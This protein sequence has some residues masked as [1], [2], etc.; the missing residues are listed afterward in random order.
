MR[1]PQIQP[2]GIMIKPSSNPAAKRSQNVEYLRSIMEVLVAGPKGA[3][4]QAAG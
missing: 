3:A 4:I 1:A 2:T